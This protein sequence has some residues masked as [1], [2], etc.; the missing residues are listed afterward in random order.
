[1]KSDKKRY[2]QFGLRK[3]P[4]IPF[5]IGVY[6]ACFGFFF[7]LISST[8]FLGV[9]GDKNGGVIGTCF[10]LVFAGIGIA[11]AV[12]CKKKDR[13]N[14]KIKAT[15]K[16]VRA[17]VV[18]DVINP[19]V[20]INGKCP[21]RL[22]LKTDGSITAPVY[23]LSDDVYIVFNM[24]KAKGA[25]ADVYLDGDNYY[26]DLN[27]MAEGKLSAEDEARFGAPPSVITSLPDLNAFLT[28]YPD[29]SVGRNDTEYA[30]EPRYIPET[31]ID[32]FNPFDVDK[33]NEDPFS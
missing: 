20:H 22:V 2:R 7:F 15:G 18:G 1:M 17:Q 29:S 6:F 28:A 10:G 9:Q 14:A 31:P 11:V 19:N 33:S 21:D 25:Y 8:V 30:E 32:E 12:L 3:I 13:H 23:Y 5:G 16:Y 24:N 26:V 4:N 27:S